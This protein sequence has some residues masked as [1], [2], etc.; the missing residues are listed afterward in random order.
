M[1]AITA[2][3]WPYP[4]WIAHRG[5]G[6]LAPENTLA[7]FRLGAQHGYRMFECDAKLSAD[8]VPFLLHDAT[9]ERTTNGRGTGGDLPLGALA[10]LDAGSWHSRAYAGEAVPTL[11]ALARFCIANGY[12][13]NIEIK[14]TPGQ[15]ETTGRVVGETAA[16]LWQ[17]QAVPPLF[18]SFKPDALA[19]AQATAAHIPRALLL[20]TLWDGCLDTARSLGCVA[21]VCNHALWDAALVAQVKDM[22]MRT[23]SYTVND[24]WAAQ[25]LIA[26]GTDGIIT[27][28]VD[29]FSPATP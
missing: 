27:D 8:G 17:G 12:F 1:N 14:P 21:I 15:E 23:L 19:G 18:S 3:S 10:Q 26:L 2:S 9:L 25:R 11:E 7:A 4:R 5:A 24:D 6:K 22:G 28:R 20:D 16:R 29:L 13:L